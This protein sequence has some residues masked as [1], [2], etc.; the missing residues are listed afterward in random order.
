MGALWLKKTDIKLNEDNFIIVN[1][2]FQ[3]NFKFIFAA[4]IHWNILSPL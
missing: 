2:R 4:E 1:D 3:T